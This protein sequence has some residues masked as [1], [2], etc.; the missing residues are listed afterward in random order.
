MAKIK[1]DRTQFNKVLESIRKQSKTAAEV[2]LKLIQ[3]EFKSEAESLGT[4]IQKVI[5]D[6]NA[7]SF[8][9]NR[10]IILTG[11][12][13]KSQHISYRRLQGAVRWPVKNPEN[14][15][16]YANAVYTGW[17][18]FGTGKFIPG[19]KYPELGLKRKPNLRLQMKVEVSNKGL[20]AYIVPLL[21][22][23]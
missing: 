2:Y 16:P 9:P 11:E 8:L 14:G 5:S 7:F 10:D 19:R 13:K 4:S 3:N 1:I 6:T 20:I 12:L 23:Y 15:F 18:P 22:K 21:D 17:K